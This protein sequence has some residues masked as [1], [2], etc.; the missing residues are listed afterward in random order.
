MSING[1]E[2]TFSE[3]KMYLLMA[4]LR[5]LCYTDKSSES[6]CSLLSLDEMAEPGERL[7]LTLQQLTQA[8]SAL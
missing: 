8:V 4:F 3:K 6:K 5:A 1:I 2:Q 7:S